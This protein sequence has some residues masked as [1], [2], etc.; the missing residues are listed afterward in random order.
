M[1]LKYELQKLYAQAVIDLFMKQII[2]KI[3]ICF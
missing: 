2:W 1:F 3:H